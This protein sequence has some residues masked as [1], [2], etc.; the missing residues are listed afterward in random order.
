[1]EECIGK[2]TRINEVISETPSMLN[3]L[4]EQFL[5]YQ[6]LTENDIP[7][8]VWDSASVSADEPASADRH[9]RM[10]VLWGHLGTMFPQLSEI[11]LSVLVIPHSNAVEERVFSMVRKNL[12]EFISRLEP[13]GSLNAIMRI[14]MSLPENLGACYKWK[15]SKELLKKCKTATMA[16]NEHCSK[17][18][19]K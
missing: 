14:K 15:P 5:Q 11:A 3:E 13:S 16:Y 6:S 1:M 12:N 19:G 2:L 8:H 9:Y 10:D 18:T 4:E 7:D 17:N